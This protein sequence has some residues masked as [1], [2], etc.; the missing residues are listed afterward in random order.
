MGNIVVTKRQQQ[1]WE[2][3]DNYL[4]FHPDPEEKESDEE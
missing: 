4:V 1:R 2:Y 3:W